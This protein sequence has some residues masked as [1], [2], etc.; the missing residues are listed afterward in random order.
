MIQLSN[1]KIGLDEDRDLGIRKT[2]ENTLKIKDFEFFIVKESI[3]ARKNPI[4]FVYQVNVKTNLEKNLINKYP[5][6]NIVTEE[7][8]E[9][10]TPGSRKLNS[11]PVVIGFGPSGLFAALELARYGYKPLVLERGKGVD[12]RK[13]DVDDFWTKGVLNP[14][15]NVQFGEGGAGTFS[16]GKLTTRIK[17]KRVKS[18]LKDLYKFGSPEE[19]LFAHKPHVGTDILEKVVKNIRNEIISLGGEVRFNSKVDG[20]NTQNGEIKQVLVNGEYIDADGVILAIGHSSRDTFRALNKAGVEM[21]SKPFAVGFRIEHP[22]VSI[23]KAQYKENYAHPKLKS[24]EYHLTNQTQKGRSCYTFCMCPGGRVIGSSSSKGE[25]V[26]NG[27]SY[28]ARDLENANSAILC[29]VSSLDYGEDLFSGVEFQEKIEKNAFEL[30]GSDYFAPVQRIEDFLNKKETVSIGEVIP[31]YEPGY[32]FAR[33][34]RLYSEFITEAISE[35]IINMGKKLKGFDLSDGILTGVETRSSSPVRILRDKTLESV[36]TQGL[37]PAG[38][39]AGY[40]GG[41]VSAGVDGIKA[42]QGLIIKFSKYE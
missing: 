12:E 19:I 38:E 18:I 26:V 37:F 21:E 39:G 16:D 24:A 2:I 36:N 4:F 27:M 14:E 13:L 23:D 1:I 42:A 10:L 9:K 41:I 22:Q 17:D 40:A 11:R 32:K 15:S 7:E 33:L 20:F 29:A 28:N 5:K 34:D 25:L 31:S 8:P 3:D 30:G 35:S 6:L